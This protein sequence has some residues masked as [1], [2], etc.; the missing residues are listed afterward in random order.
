MQAQ[1]ILKDVV[2]SYS[3]I[4]EEFHATR[5][6]PW[7]EFDIFLN[8]MDF[9][10]SPKLLDV[11]C[12]NGRLLDFFKD[13]SIEYTG[14]DNNKKLLTL[15]KKAHPKAEF[16]YGDI[17]KIPFPANTFDTVWCIAVLHHIPTEELQL[18][19]LK[20]MHRVLKSKGKLMLTVWNLWQLKYLK[21]ID[22]KTHDSFIPWGPSFA[23]A[24]DGK[25]E[26]KTT[27]YYHAFTSPEVRKLLKKSGFEL[28]KEI[29]LKGNFNLSYV[30]EKS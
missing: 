21:Y 29:K 9:E 19:A 10:E 2:T 16:K 28:K 5:D 14:L 11:G 22:E 8:Q 26:K 15:A 24:S 25:P 7:P 18:K 1:K 23:K 3:K 20:E 4:A 12:G 6:H 30:Y 27:R 17:L 13:H